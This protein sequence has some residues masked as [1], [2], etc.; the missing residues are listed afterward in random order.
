MRNTIVIAGVFLGFVI[1]WSPPARGAVELLEDFTAVDELAGF[2]GGAEFYENPG[3]GGVGGDGG[4]L[5]VRNASAQ[6]NLAT[7]NVGPTYTGDWTGIDYVIFYIND[8]NVDGCNAAENPFEIHVGIGAG[9]SNFWLS[10]EG[11]VAP[12]D[13]WLRCDVE[14]VES[15]FHQIGTA[16]TFLEALQSSSRFV[17]RHDDTSACG[18]NPI[19]CL[20]DVGANND[21]IQG[22]LGIDRIIL[23]EDCF[24][25]SLPGPDCNGNGIL[26]DCDFATGASEDCNGNNVPDTCDIDSGLSFDVNF[27]RI[28]D[29]CEDFRACCFGN[30]GC[31][32]RVLENCS[33]TPLAPG[34]TCASEKGGE[35]DACLGACCVLDPLQGLTCVLGTASQCADPGEVFAGFGV[36]CE[37]EPCSNLIPTVSQWGMLG[38][39]LLVLTVGTLVYRRRWPAHA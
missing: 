5:L 11:F 26:D 28:P 38:M 39:T 22:D 37:P 25:T 20:D 19:P 2:G 31:S 29:E 1:H 9:P 12:C 7:R 6:S 36:P 27:N 4:Y 33:G 15:K 23:A 14:L 30:G 17:L 3:E 21:L 10:I 18:D 16:G 35:D 8:V 34:S 13:A 24:L 32:F